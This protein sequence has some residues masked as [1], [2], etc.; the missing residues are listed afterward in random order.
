M[1]G[2]E[3]YEARLLRRWPRLRFHDLGDLALGQASLLEV[4]Q[5]YYEGSVE[6]LEAQITEFEN[7]TPPPDRP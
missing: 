3:N 6:E 2:Q 4:L 5:R 1:D 7:M